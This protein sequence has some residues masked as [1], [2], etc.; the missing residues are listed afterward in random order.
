MTNLEAIELEVSFL[1][2]GVSMLWD[3]WAMLWNSWIYLLTTV[4][5]AM[6]M[7]AL[8]ALNIL[9]NGGRP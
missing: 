8:V 9:M 5:E 7:F 2:G 3:S 1:R 6:V 4:L